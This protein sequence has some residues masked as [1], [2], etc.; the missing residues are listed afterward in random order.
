MD[1]ENFVHTYPQVFHLA[2]RD[3][4]EGIQRHG[5]MSTTAL[6]DLF[7]V[8][9]PLRS[10][11]ERKIRKRSF[12]LEHPTHGEARIRD[13]KPISYA[14]LARCL[15]GMTAEEWLLTL[16]RR[17]FFWTSPARL[18]RLL[19]AKEYRD[20]PHLVLTVDT[21]CLLK[22]YGQSAELCPYNSGNTLF[23]PP[24]RG[25][26]TFLGISDYPFELWRSKRRLS[27]AVVELTIDYAVTEIKECLLKAEEIEGTKSTVLWETDSLN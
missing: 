4:W 3:S 14:G 27:D 25:K 10:E 17:V 22:R 24:P 2:E 11:I 5:L 6:L 8:A 7:E 13:Q 15:V 18:H 20:R 21:S 23:N 12:Q 9:E 26:G 1:V 16:N 19:I